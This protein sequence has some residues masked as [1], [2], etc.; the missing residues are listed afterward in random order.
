MFQPCLSF[1]LGHVLLLWL[2]GNSG[3]DTYTCLFFPF[4]NKALILEAREY[5]YARCLEELTLK[6]N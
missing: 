4:K 5:Y 1:D 3:R 2:I 6:M